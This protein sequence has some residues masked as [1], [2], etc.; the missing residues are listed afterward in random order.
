MCF[1]LRYS[2]SFE[3]GGPEII[4]R[5]PAIFSFWHRAMIPAGYIFRKFGF[6][7]LSS[8]SFDGQLMARTIQRLGFCTVWGSSSRGALRALLGMRRE[9]EQ[10]HSAA[11][12]IDGPRGPKFVAKQG[13]VF[14]ASSTGAPMAAFYI[15]LE[16]PWILNT[17]DQTMIPRPFSRALIRF[18]PLIHVPADA[19]EAAMERYQSKLQ[20]ALERVTAFAETNVS[21]VGSE[22]FPFTKKI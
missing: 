2:L 3:Q 4:Q 9:L 16:N 8:T 14:L 18:S 6:R 13:P 10:G 11:F 7:V 22:E 12:T 5:K 19:D 17:W 20:Q 21:K 1:T 15:A